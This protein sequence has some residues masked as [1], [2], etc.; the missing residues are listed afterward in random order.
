MLAQFVVVLVTAGYFFITADLETGLAALFGGII[1][2]VNTLLL[3]WNF[4]RAERIAG[5][6]NAQ[7]N[8]KLLYKT[9]GL[10]LFS[11]IGLFVLAL[12]VLRLPPEPLFIGF[13]AGLA[14]LLVSR[15]GFKK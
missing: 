7:Q 2:L 3:R 10:R 12:G 15:I 4:E 13:V 14:A 11:T 1:A 5:N 8:L 6:S 9:A